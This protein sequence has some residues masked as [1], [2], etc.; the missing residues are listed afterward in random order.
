MNHFRYSMSMTLL[1]VLCLL[2]STVLVS[3]S[4]LPSDD[5]Q[6][7]GPN[8]GTGP[9]PTG[10]T[11]EFI[12]RLEKLDA[13]PQIAPESIHWE[14]DPSLALKMPTEVLSL[15]NPYSIP[16][17]A[18]SEGGQNSYNVGPRTPVVVESESNNVANSADALGTTFPVI[19]NGSI[20]KNDDDWFYID[21]DG[22]TGNN[23]QNITIQLES[24][25][26]TSGPGTIDH[27][28]WIAMYSST[29]FLGSQL[30]LM[31]YNAWTFGQ[32]FWWEIPWSC[33]SYNGRYFIAL[34][35][36]VRDNSNPQYAYSCTVDVNDV[37]SL[38]SNDDIQN[39]E[40]IT[41][42]VSDKMVLCDR[43]GFDW[44]KIDSPAYIGYDYNTSITVRIDNEYKNTVSPYDVY[45]ILHVYFFYEISPGAYTG[46]ILSASKESSTNFV[47]P[48]SH[49][50]INTAPTTYIGVFERTEAKHQT[51]GQT[52]IL[53]VPGED[54]GW[55]EYRFSQLSVDTV[56]P[57]RLLGGGVTPL[58]GNYEDIFTFN[59]TYYDPDED[60]LQGVWLNIGPSGTSTI[61]AYPMVPVPNQ[62]GDLV[63]GEK[64]WLNFTGAQLMTG[65]TPPKSFAYFFTAQDNEFTA[66]LPNSGGFSGPAVI[67]NTKPYILV[68]SPASHIM[69]EDDLPFELALAYI[70]YDNELNRQ[71]DPDTL[72][73][74]LYDPQLDKWVDQMATDNLTATVDESRDVLILTPKAN[75]YGVD[76]ILLNATDKYGYFV[77][78]PH[79]LTVTIDPVND[80]PVIQTVAG[81]PP[82]NGEVSVAL[83]E[84]TWRDLSIICFDLDGDILQYGM[85][86][87]EEL[88]SF[89]DSDEAEILHLEFDQLSGNLS[90]MPFNSDV[91]SHEVEVTVTDGTVTDSVRM[92]IDV[93]NTNDAPV[94]TGIQN[95][96]VNEGATVF[97]KTEQDR[98]LVINMEATDPDKEVQQDLD[99]LTYYTDFEDVLDDED[100]DLDEGEN[101]EFDEDMGTLKFTPDNSM[102]GTYV[103]S[104]WVEDE[105][106]ERDEVNVS[107]QV[108][109]KNDLPTKAEFRVEIV[110]GDRSTPKILENLTVNFIIT[111]L[112]DDPDV[113]DTITYE[114]DFGD[115]SPPEAGIDLLEIEHTY[116]SPGNYTINLTTKDA[117]HATPGPFSMTIRVY[118]VSPPVEIEDDDDEDPEE[119]GETPAD[120]SG[121]TSV[122][123]WI[124]IV[125]IIVVLLLVVFFVVMSK[126]KKEEMAAQPPLQPGQSFPMAQAAG[127][128][129]ASPNPLLTSI[130]DGEPSQA[131]SSEPPPL[132]IGG[133]EAPEQLPSKEILLL[134]TTEAAPESAA[135]T[136]EGGG[137]GVCSSCGE[138]IEAHAS[139]CGLRICSLAPHPSPFKESLDKRFLFLRR[140]R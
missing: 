102:V 15:E 7:D 79:P 75:Q 21:L 54:K 87:E 74:S 91:G 46:V 124:I 25:V 127:S 109:N 118:K 12:P 10:S 68:G 76:R 95:K 50:L 44:Y 16:Q 88:P 125:I 117:L 86:I 43:D 52:Y 45:T 20:N 31:T 58:E 122:W 108:T 119:G 138:N 81:E 106:E 38:D 137:E 40:T 62:D 27:Y 37:P 49:K 4:A 28:M 19:V 70:F 131:L 126:K 32:T 123:L 84:D 41:G 120:A 59:V 90:F 89:D 56:A 78:S 132:S 14:T 30:H 139:A 99:S 2:L 64:F 6:T 121:G 80:P 97:F 17:N 22:L 35:F 101:W 67:N 136:E 107:I 128:G 73:F 39:A 26:N 18:P 55:C 8:D 33:T 24:L 23:V 66:T 11:S 133:T 134:H 115:S 104:M 13:P 98:E 3:V 72:E 140:N 60:A 42:P 94:I 51:T 111:K 61:T 112:G 36:N 77:S 96:A 53:N 69:S 92:M 105:D 65:L 130:G 103:F 135:G 1:T 83:Y 85:T 110:D 113:D 63:N 129:A 114:W 29:T 100:I 93:I 5:Q 9:S 47:N 82:V 116:F 34:S 71:S 57:C 48:V